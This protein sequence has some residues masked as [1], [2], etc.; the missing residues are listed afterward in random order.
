MGGTSFAMTGQAKATTPLKGGSDEGCQKEKRRYHEDPDMDQDNLIS[1]NS[2]NDES[3]GG[4]FDQ[5]KAQEIFDDWM[6]SM[7]VD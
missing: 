4:D 3:E 1:E 5:A 7:R 6:N 2:E